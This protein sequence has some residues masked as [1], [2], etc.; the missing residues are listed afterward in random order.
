MCVR[1]RALA[2]VCE[3]GGALTERAAALDS[4]SIAGKEE[5]KCRTKN[6]L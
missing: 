6:S 3:K 2:R 4:E 1:A 5:K